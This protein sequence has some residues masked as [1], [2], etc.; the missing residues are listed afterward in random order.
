MNLQRQPTFSQSTTSTWTLTWISLQVTL[1]FR[2][3]SVYDLCGTICVD[4]VCLRVH[5]LCI[6]VSLCTLTAVCLSVCLSVCCKRKLLLRAYL[7]VSFS[8]FGF[9]R[10]CVL[11]I[12][13]VWFMF[14]SF[15]ICAFSVYAAV[16][17]DL[18]VGIRNSIRAVKNWVICAS[19]VICVEIH[20]YDSHT[21]Q[22]MPLPPNHLLLQLNPEC[23]HF[24]T[25][26]LRPVADP[27]GE[28]V[29]GGRAMPSPLSPR[30]QPG[31]WSYSSFNIIYEL[32][33]L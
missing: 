29:G 4:C 12:L 28:A 23:L 3:D 1:W 14:G 8:L 31:N 27:R 18:L 33:N 20:S 9:F 25:C 16:A 19:V 26:Q 2:S 17:F 11:L 24:S 30:W 7:L 13:L 22:L 21:V 32:V 10:K 5:I 15:F 6:A